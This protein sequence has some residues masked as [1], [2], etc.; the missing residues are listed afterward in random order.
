MYHTNISKQKLSLPIPIPFISVSRGVFRSQTN[1][2][3]RVPCKQSVAPMQ[4]KRSKVFTFIAKS[5]ILNV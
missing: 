3:D 4:T 2:K 5:P 1:I